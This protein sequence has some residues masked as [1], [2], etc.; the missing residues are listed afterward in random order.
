MH[1][2]CALLPVVQVTTEQRSHAKAMSYGLLYGK[3]RSLDLQQDRLSR[4]CRYGFQAACCYMPLCSRK[5]NG[6]GANKLSSGGQPL[7]RHLCLARRT[8]R[9]YALPIDRMSTT[10]VA[11]QTQG[12]HA[13]AQDLR[14]DVN[15]AMRERDLFLRTMPGVRKWQARCRCWEA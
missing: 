1:K 9:E 7:R 11:M 13:L 2:C 6:G 15:T 4:I 8:V 14:S 10:P 3:V 12:V 5:P